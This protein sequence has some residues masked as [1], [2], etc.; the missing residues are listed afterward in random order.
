MTAYIA[1][2]R[3]APDSDFSV[4]FPDFP[5]CA[6][7]GKTLDE[8]V[9]F[10]KEALALHLEGFEAEGLKIPIPH[11]LDAVTDASDAI[12]ILIPIPT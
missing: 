3:K 12:A 9:S 5:G 8:A 1:L 6:T 4:D 11:S 7:A 2:I 10:A